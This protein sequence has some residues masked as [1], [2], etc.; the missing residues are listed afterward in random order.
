MPTMWHEEKHLASSTRLTGSLLK[1]KIRIHINLNN[2]II[3]EI[4]SKSAQVKTTRDGWFAMLYKEKQ[5]VLSP[6]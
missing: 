6:A 3:M 1:Y 2:A 4:E 5:E